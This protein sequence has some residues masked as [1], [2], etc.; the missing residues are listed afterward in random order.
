MSYLHHDCIPHIIHRDIKSS[1]ILL[2]QNMKARVSDF[3]LAPDRPM[4]RHLW[5]ELLNTLI[6]GE[7][8]QK[9]MYTVTGV[10]LLELL[11]GEKPTDE[12]FVEEGTKL[13]TWVKS[14]VHEKMEVHVLDRTLENSPIDEI[15][16]VF[17]IA[18]MCLELEPSKRKTM[19]EVVKM[20]EQMRPEKS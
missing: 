7:R 1:N 6:R 12:A 16:N 8:L 5:L 2:D 15:N 19:A 20:L 11:A 17:S 4:S 14:A 13:V 18:L 9:G 3:G 10:V